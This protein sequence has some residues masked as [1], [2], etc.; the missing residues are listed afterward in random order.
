MWSESLDGTDKYTRRLRHLVVLF[1]THLLAA[2]LLDRV[3]RL[4]PWWLVV[5]AA[6]PDLLDKPLAS[7]GVFELFHTVGHSALVAVPVALVLATRGARRR[8]VAV[9]WLSHLALDTLHVV[10]NGRPTDAYSLAWPLARPPTPL[11][12]PPG[13]FFW[14]YLGS[15]SFVLEVGIWLVGL[16][17]LWRRLDAPTVASQ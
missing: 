1:P 2:A 9:G 5:G 11:G 3:T 4:S 14:Y 17:V 12:I 13:E 16:V 10:I 8:A 7:L 15:P 6:V